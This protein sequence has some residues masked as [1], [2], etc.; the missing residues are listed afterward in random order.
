[1]AAV[2]ILGERHTL[3]SLQKR[4]TKIGKLLVNVE[5]P[6]ALAGGFGPSHSSLWRPVSRDL[7][8]SP[9]MV[10]ERMIRKMNNLL[11]A[12]SRDLAPFAEKIDEGVGY[13]KFSLDGEEKKVSDLEALRVLD[14]KDLAAILHED[15]RPLPGS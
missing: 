11:L 5:T 4:S 6:A 2:Y 15:I 12:P 8:A 7:M 9:A 1:M 10:I 14:G 13:I 3:P